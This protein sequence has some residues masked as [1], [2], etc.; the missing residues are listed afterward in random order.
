MKTILFQG[1]SIT[2]VGR[3]REAVEAAWM[4]GGGYP[5]VVGAMLGS[6]CPGKYAFYNR[7][8]SGD[9]VVDVYARIKKDILNLRPDYM[10]L[11]I[12]VNDVWHEDRQNGVDAVKFEKIY[13]M[14]IDEIRAELP[15]IK[16]I[17]LGAF[18]TEG[19]ELDGRYAEF[20]A[21][22]EKRAAAAKR[23]A[24]EKGCCFVDL[25]HVFDEA[26]KKAPATYWTL[27]GVHPL[28]PG[29]GLIANEWLKTF[30]TMK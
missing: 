28:S 6:S 10:S 27:E 26:C 11:L 22:V 1:D 29:H 25:Q 17:L 24:E 4:T 8:V 13:R 12:G 2:D 15:N 16:F 18:V 19:Y 7:G 14:L 21:E 30:E 9:R 20:R 3:N 5:T 23:I